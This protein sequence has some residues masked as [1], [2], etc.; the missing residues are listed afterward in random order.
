MLIVLGVLALVTGNVVGGVWWFVL[1]LFLRSAAR[2]SYQQLL[3]RRALEG[4]SIERFMQSEVLLVPP[5][6]T[7]DTF[8]DDYV[9]EYHHKMFPVV[10]NGSLRG[11]MTTAKL[12]SMPREE[13]SQRR[14]EDMAEPCGE[15][16]TIDV[17]ADATEALS[18]MTRN[19]HSRLMV[20]DDGQL[21]GV[22]SL[23]DMMAF[24]ANKVELEDPLDV[25]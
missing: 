24:I 21:C 4:E 10:A 17:H 8:V 5:D 22:L 19:G 11:C 7:L 13:W 23:R 18:K 6:I 12:K 15:P 25:R 2:M 20:V 14:V 1:G 16:N 9:F 3:V